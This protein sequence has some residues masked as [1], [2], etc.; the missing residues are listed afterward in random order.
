MAIKKRAAALI[1]AGAAFTAASYALTDYI[2]RKALDRNAGK[3]PNTDTS[4]M[5]DDP[6]AR[7]KGPGQQL[8]NTPHERVEITS[9]DGLKLVG[10]WFEHEEPK[11]VILAAHGWKASWYRDFGYSYPFLKSENCSVLYIEQR[12]QGESEGRYLG[13]GLLERF[14]IIDWLGWL[15]ERC[16]TEIPIYLAGISMGAT[17]VLMASGEELPPNVKGIIADCG[18]TSPTEIWKHVAREGMH[19]PFL[20]TDL[21]SRILCKRMIGVSPAS[22]STVDA[23]RKNKVPVLFIHG[24]DDSFVPVSMTKENYEACAAPKEI[25]IVPGAIH[26][27]SYAVAKEAY[28]E[29]ERQFWARYD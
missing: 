21:Y 9:H 6:Y 27:M 19:L 24:Q 3:L 26:G 28:E 12:S 15:E 14:D 25:M 8:R 16:G 4:K 5:K 17:S 20:I 2:L 29:K 10:H 23:L 1:G 13:F 11:R 18:F 7:F 22:Y